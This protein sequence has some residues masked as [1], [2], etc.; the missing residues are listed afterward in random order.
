MS[1]LTGSVAFANLD[2]HEMYQGQSTG[3]YSIV[4]T[5]DEANAA[6]LTDAGVKLRDYEG[7]SQRKFASKFHIDVVDIDGEPCKERITRGSLVRIQYTLG[8]EHPV[9]GITPYLDKIRVLELSNAS[10]EDF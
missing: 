9:H 6:L 1:V 7:N 4:L 8:Q 10:D 3:K 5:L 2:E